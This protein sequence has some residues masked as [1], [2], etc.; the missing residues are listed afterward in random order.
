MGKRGRKDPRPTRVSLMLW[1]DERGRAATR[2]PLSPGWASKP[3]THSLGV[4][5][6]AAQPGS[7]GTT[8][9]SPRVMGEREEGIKVPTPVRVSTVDLDEQRLSMVLELYY[10]KA[11]RKREG[12][13]R[14]GKG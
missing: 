14:E 10:R 1:S 6:G 4:G 8:P 2:F 12:R 11:G 7:P 3:L 9:C 13:K 5:Q